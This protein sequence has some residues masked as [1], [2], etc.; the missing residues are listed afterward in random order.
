MEQVQ[1]ETEVGEEIIK[2]CRATYQDTSGYLHITNIRIIWTK[3][4][5]RTAAFS[6]PFSKIKG[7]TSKTINK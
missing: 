2:Q 3:P 1:I 5:V 4:A 7:L 6:L